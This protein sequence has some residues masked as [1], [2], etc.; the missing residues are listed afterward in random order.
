[1][2]P[3]GTVT[4]LFTDIQGSTP[5]WEQQPQA[6]RAALERHNEILHLAIRG[7]N[8]H[9]FQIVGD[10]FCAAFAIPAQAVTAAIAAQRRLVKAE[11]G[12]TGPLRVRMG[13]HR[14]GRDYG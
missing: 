7:N 14:L 4:F 9:V 8:G 11:W 1:V 6:M 12:E 5:L 13:I 10:A 3:S 2:L